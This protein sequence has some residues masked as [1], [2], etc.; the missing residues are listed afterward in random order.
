M[1][2]EL[3]TPAGWPDYELIDSGNSRKLERYGKYV[4]DRPE[5][6]AIWRPRLASDKWAHADATFKLGEDGSEGWVE[7]S[8]I[9]ERWQMRHDQLRFWAQLTPFRHTGVFPEQSVNWRW[10]A[11]QV[12]K[13]RRPVRVLDLFGY[14]GIASLAAAAAGASVTYLD[15][16]K[17]AMAWARDN[18]VESGLQDRPVRWILDD[19]LKFVRREARRGT[20]YDAIIMDPPVFG[21]GAKGEIWRFPTGFPQLID[22]CREVLTDDPLFVLVNAYAINFSSVMLGNVLAELM[23]AHRG[24]LTVGELAL[25]ESGNGRLLSTGI[26]GRWAAGRGD[27]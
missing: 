2:I 24:T 21:R 18:Q 17:Q 25:A 23:A 8:A 6:E 27:E 10:I 20:R 7:H 22:A 26:F 13:A 16:S 11:R 4:L 19:A 15:A 9:G 14:T 1:R 12:E 3:L 5:P